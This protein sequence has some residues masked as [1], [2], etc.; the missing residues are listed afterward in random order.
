M[1]AEERARRCRNCGASLVGL[2]DGGE[3]E[4]P[5]ERPSRPTPL[6]S[7]IHVEPK[8]ARVDRIE[9]PPRTL[10]SLA[11]SPD[12]TP[13]SALGPVRRWRSFASGVGLGAFVVSIAG[14]L[15]YAS[16]TGTSAPAT[17]WD[18][19]WLHAPLPEAPS[20]HAVA[21]PRSPSVETGV[22]STA[23]ERWGIV[24]EIDVS[25]GLDFD[26]PATAET[27]ELIH[28]KIPA[29]VQQATGVRLREGLPC[30]INVRLRNGKARSAPAEAA[31][32]PGSE[33]HS[34]DVDCAGHILYDSLAPPESNAPRDATL[35]EVAGRTPDAYAYRLIYSDVAAAPGRPQIELDSFEMKASV[36]TE[37]DSAFR[38]ELRIGLETLSREGASL[39]GLPR[40]VYKLTRE[41]RRTSTAG[42]LPWPVAEPC[43]F[44][45]H[46]ILASAEGLFCKAKLSCSGRTLY[47]VRNSVGRC[48]V[49]NQTILGF[50]DLMQGSEDQSPALNF[51][52]RTGVVDVED[53]TD[54]RGHYRVRFERAY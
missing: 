18:E 11:P 5:R 43:L 47:G 14:L 48:T 9:V 29:R 40:G 7:S 54:E 36:F 3:F 33:L 27:A 15:H 17:D 20:P 28:T 2:L 52:A 37:G 31:P 26:A 6:T 22:E 51:D 21:N 53:S 46:L 19:A 50:Y 45:A 44:E 42:A 32:L 23:E 39:L 12:A 35:Y 24:E 13:V 30:E 10:D 4:V 25:E 49:E 16:H 34:L 8:A 41:L 38:V 1:P